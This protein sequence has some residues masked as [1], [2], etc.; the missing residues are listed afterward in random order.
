MCQFDKFCSERVLV[1]LS[2]G[3]H[4]SRRGLGMAQICSF[5]LLALEPGAAKLS[6]TCFPVCHVWLE[7]THPLG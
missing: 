6:Q 5:T 1:L 2:F 7:S 3:F 4:S